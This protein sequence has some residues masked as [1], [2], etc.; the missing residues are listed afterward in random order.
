M[1]RYMYLLF[2]D[3]GGQSQVTIVLRVDVL[4]LSL[5]EVQVR[6]VSVVISSFSSFQLTLV[7]GSFE[8]EFR[9][10]ISALFHPCDYIILRRLH[11]VAMWY[12]LS[13]SIDISVDFDGCSL[14]GGL[15]EN[16]AGCETSDDDP[17]VAYCACVPPFT[18]DLCNDDARVIGACDVNVMRLFSNACPTFSVVV[19]QSNALRRQSSASE[20]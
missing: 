12:R 17:L 11:L 4:T 18:G 3:V 8:V 14:L 2:S 13:V 9:F 20:V 6:A 7:A 19:L 1:Y 10:T 15:C 16:G 5:Q